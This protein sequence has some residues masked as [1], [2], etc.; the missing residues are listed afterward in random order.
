MSEPN[1]C[2]VLTEAQLNCGKRREFIC[3]KNSKNALVE[4]QTVNLKKK[5]MSQ[6]GATK[7]FGREQKQLAISI[8]SGGHAGGAAA[9]RRSKS[10]PRVVRIVLN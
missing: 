3:D 8:D 7:M 4:F 6:D 5:K 10:S 2:I 1:L 9:L